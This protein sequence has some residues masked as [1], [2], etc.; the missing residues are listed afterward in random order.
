MASLLSVGCT[1]LTA[2][3]AS[4]SVVGLPTP[5][6]HQ[7][8]QDELSTTLPLSSKGATSPPV[9]VASE[10]QK[11]PAA[12]DAAPS[13]SASAAV[14][15]GGQ[16]GPVSQTRPVESG[17]SAYV[18]ERDEEGRYYLGNPEGRVVIEEWLDLHSPDCTLAFKTIG[19]IVSERGTDVKVVFHHFP[20]SEKRIDAAEAVEAAGEQGRFWPMLEAVLTHQTELG[21]V[22][23][24]RQAR[25][26]GLDIQVL[27]TSIRARRHVDRI[28]A[29]REQALRL[30]FGSAPVFRVNGGAPLFAPSYHRLSSAVQEAAASAVG[31]SIKA[32]AGDRG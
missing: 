10:P 6:R 20:Q 17:A 24:Q 22:Y 8:A 11:R 25:F 4:E 30:G 1:A 3:F 29:D 12:R 18:T 32:G 26:L 27:Q 21:P 31:Q 7:A 9:G 19:R 28:V 16:S 2:G 13:T 5:V 15:S 23:Y 14:P